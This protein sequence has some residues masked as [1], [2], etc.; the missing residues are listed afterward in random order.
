M[1][2]SKFMGRVELTQ[3]QPPPMLR[4]KSLY[5]KR[6]QNLNQPSSR[7]VNKLQKLSPSTK[8]RSKYS[9]FL[10]YAILKNL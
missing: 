8:C 5:I 9:S 10:K 6:I 3:P 2:R 1:E 7:S 4:A